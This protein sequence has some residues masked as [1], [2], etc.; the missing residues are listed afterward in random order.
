[1]SSCTKGRLGYACEHCTATYQVVPRD[2][3]YECGSKEFFPFEL[4]FDEVPQYMN[5]GKED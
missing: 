3:C 4:W 1:M 2:G 5:A